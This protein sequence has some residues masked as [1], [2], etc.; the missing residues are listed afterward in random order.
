[1][2]HISFDTIVFQFFEPVI[3]FIGS[4][5]VWWEVGGP[6][7]RWVMYVEK[8]VCDLDNRLIIR[9]ETLKKIRHRVEI[10]R[11]IF[12][13][14]MLYCR[15]LVEVVRRRRFSQRYSLVNTFNV[16]TTISS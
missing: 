9:H 16:K 5:W 7:S 1:M 8:S 6:A 4:R 11:Q 14:P 15:A 10:I 3:D 13:S 2:L 12:D